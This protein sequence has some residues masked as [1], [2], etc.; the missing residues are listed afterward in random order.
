MSSVQS[1][2]KNVR[3]KIGNKWT[4]T[5][6]RNN[7]S[8]SCKLQGNTISLQEKKITMAD[9]DNKDCFITIFRRAKARKTQWQQQMEGKLNEMSKEIEAS[10]QSHHL[11]I[12]EI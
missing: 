11:D 1:V 12:D 7:H 5:L 3:E 4:F 8:E 9:I 6:K 2:R 10:K